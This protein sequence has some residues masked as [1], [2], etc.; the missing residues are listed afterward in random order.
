MR[1]TPITREAS[2]QPNPARP[3]LCASQSHPRWGD[4][5]RWHEWLNRH[6]APVMHSFAQRLAKRSTHREILTYLYRNRPRGQLASFDGCAFWQDWRN[7]ILLLLALISRPS[8]V[9]A[10]T[11]AAHI[12]EEKPYTYLREWGIEFKSFSP[13]PKITASGEGRTLHGSLHYLSPSYYLKSAGRWFEVVYHPY[14]LDEWKVRLDPGPD[15]TLNH[16]RL[17]AHASTRPVICRPA[18]VIPTHALA[19]QLDIYSRVILGVPVMQDSTDKQGRVPIRVLSE[20][21]GPDA[22]M[23]ASKVRNLCQCQFWNDLAGT[24]GLTNRRP[25]QRCAD[26]Q[27]LEVT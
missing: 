17:A 8:T 3:P 19:E 27:P 22:V 26:H 23:H 15:L 2:P 25:K 24:C 10:F 12:P 18:S 11:Q 1:L 20:L 5:Y 7:R 9:A 4:A 6:A 16:A 21:F 14:P 13:P